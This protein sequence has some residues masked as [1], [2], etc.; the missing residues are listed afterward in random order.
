[1]KILKNIGLLALSIIGPLIF[2]EKFLTLYKVIEQPRQPAGIFSV[3]AEVG[4]ILLGFIIGLAIFSTFLFTLFGD[5]NKYY[6]IGVL[7]LPVLWFVIKFDLPHWY[8]YLTIAL[9][10][11]L[12]GWVANR[13]IKAS[14]PLA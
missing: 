3:Y 14:R 10:G 13:L 12:I 11:W 2:S 1:M 6:W 5:K 9:T 8:F 4:N 7:L